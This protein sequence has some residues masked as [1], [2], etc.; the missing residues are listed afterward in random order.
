M[1]G[2]ASRNM[3]GWYIGIT[4]AS[5][6]VKAGSTP[7]PCSKIKSTTAGRAF[8]SGYLF[9]FSLRQMNCLRRKIFGRRPKMLATAHL[10][11]RPGGPRMG[12]LSGWG[13]FF[14][15]SYFIY[16]RG[17]HPRGAAPHLR[18]GGVFSRAK[19]PCNQ[20]FSRLQWG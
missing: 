16:V 1:A 20:G 10:R 19:N 3:Q 5:Q 2:G 12:E 6:A 7:V 18:G 11:R 17:K 8:Y 9:Q 4:A 13:C 14:L 15:D